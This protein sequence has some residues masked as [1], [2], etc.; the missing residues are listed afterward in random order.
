MN[1]VLKRNGKKTTIIGP[2]MAAILLGIILAL[3]SNKFLTHTNLMNILRQSAVNII[4][5]AGMLFVLLGAGIDLSQGSIVGFSMGMVT[6]LYN[7]NMNNAFLMIVLPIAVGVLCGLINGLLFTKLKLP[8]PFVS[9]LGMMEVLRGLTFIVTGAHQV[10]GFPSAVTWLGSA[11]VLSIPVCFVIVV[12]LAV[13]ISIFLNK[14]AIGREIYSVGGNKEAARL[15]GINIDKTLTITYVMSG[16]L[17]G[18][19][20][21]ILVGRVGSTYPLAGVG[22]EMDAVAACVIGGASF[23]GGKGTM[24]GT[25]IGAIIIAQ[26]KNGLNLLGASA[27]V[28]Q[29]VVGVVVV[30]AVMV[31]V[32]RTRNAEKSRRMQQARS[33][34]E[35]VAKQSA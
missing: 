11:N 32:L 29:V 6:V 34:T 15:A 16:A 26:V 2:L 12:V 10:S 35:S 23:S 17:C 4:V 22:Y 31:D 24:A 25:L 21:V 5:G 13:I 20:A 33:E 7:N 14:T 28:Q 9:T 8:H 27:D 19:A 30:L 1:K 3:A 18:L